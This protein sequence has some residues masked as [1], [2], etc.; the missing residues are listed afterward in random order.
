MRRRKFSIGDRVRVN[1]KG[2]GDYRNAEGTVVELVPDK[3]YGVALDSDER[4]P[5]HYLN[6][7]WLDRLT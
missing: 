5:V 6:S 4:A 1:D 7:W 2:P 3:Q